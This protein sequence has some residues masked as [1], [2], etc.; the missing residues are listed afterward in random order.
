MLEA[1]V[2]RTA[3]GSSLQYTLA[4][5]MALGLVMISP[6]FVHLGVRGIFVAAASIAVLAVLFGGIELRFKPWFVHLTLAALLLA[7]VSAVYWMDVRYLFAP[8][9]LLS[10]LFLIQLADDSAI[11]AFISI[12]TVLLLVML[13]GA[14]AGSALALNGVQP[15]FDIPN[16]DGRPN[17][18]FY[19]T[20][21]NSWWGGIIRPSGLYDEAGALSFMVCGVAALRHLRGRDSRVTWLLLVLGFVTLSLAHLVY[22]LLHFA[23]E[24]LGARNLVGIVATLLPV[25]LVAGY[26]GGFEVLEKRLLGRATITEAGQLA[27]DNRSDRMFNAA[28]HLD[29]HP[30]TF[31]FGAHPSCRFDYLTC[32]EKFPLMGENP[33]SPLVFQGIFLSWPYYLAL[34][35]LFIAPLF[36]RRYVVSM[37]VGALLLQRPYLLDV[38]YAL[39]GCLVLAVSLDRIMR[40]RLGRPGLFASAGRQASLAPAGGRPAAD[41]GFGGTAR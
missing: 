27:G 7:C 13:A 15:L 20:F 4:A 5:I 16:N 6:M 8:V 3:S 39:I 30:K 36:G 37:A 10:S 18:F 23:A 31:L 25:I 2:Q 28:A 22:V 40:E 29:K 24:R 26:L 11:E 32:K 38:G 34:M 19:T 41:G 12:V 21:S 17:Y 33:L 35:M 1:A 14:I 9:F